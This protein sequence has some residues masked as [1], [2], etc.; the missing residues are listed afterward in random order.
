MS[1]SATKAWIKA[2][3]AAWSARD[4]EAFSALFDDSAD[5]YWTPF[6]AP[7]RGPREISAAF[8]NAVKTQRDIRF[9]FELL[10]TNAEY[11]LAHWWC[12]FNRHGTN[13]PVQIDGIMQ[14]WLNRAGR[15]VEFR[16]WWHT[17]EAPGTAS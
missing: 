4:A 14:V 16:E 15:C 11:G 13:A 17:D 3:G 7:K 6:E 12:A 2:L 8:S 1:A 5:Y 9:G 10:N